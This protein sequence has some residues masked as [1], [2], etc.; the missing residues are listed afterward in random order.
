MPA[1]SVDDRA[2]VHAISTA[3][4]T[5]LAAPVTTVWMRGQTVLT[6]LFMLWLSFSNVWASARSS[7]SVSPSAS[8]R[9]RT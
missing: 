7:P 6:V 4:L 1:L 2:A 9:S 8:P 5:A 3:A